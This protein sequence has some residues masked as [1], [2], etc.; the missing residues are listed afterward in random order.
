MLSLSLSN[1]GRTKRKEENSV[2]RRPTLSLEYLR[3]AGTLYG[4]KPFS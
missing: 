2:S 4:P 3:P 1:Q